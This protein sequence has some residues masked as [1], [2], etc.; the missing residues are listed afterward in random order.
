MTL[1]FMASTLC[2]SAQRVPPK[3]YVMLTPSAQ[4]RACSGRHLAAW[5]CM[6]LQNAVR[7]FAEFILEPFA[8]LKGKLREGLTMTWFFLVGAMHLS[9]HGTA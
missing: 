5:R 7:W 3:L 6:P 4:L 1:V 9:P 8:P 2:T